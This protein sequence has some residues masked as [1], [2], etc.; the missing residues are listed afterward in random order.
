MNTALLILLG[1]VGIFLVCFVGLTALA[2]KTNRDFNAEVIT[3][4]PLCISIGAAMLY[5]GIC[6]GRL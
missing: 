6:V 4:E 3:W 2:K 1:C 5:S